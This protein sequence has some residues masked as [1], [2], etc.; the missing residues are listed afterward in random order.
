[1]KA[2]DWKESLKVAADE[3]PGKSLG[4]ISQIASK[5]HH[6]KRAAAATRHRVTGKAAKKEPA[7][8]CVKWEYEGEKKKTHKP[9]PA[10]SKTAV[11]VN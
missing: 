5:L 1:M 10:A 9:R 3:N 7:R 11:D 8:H 4:E 2:A 6:K